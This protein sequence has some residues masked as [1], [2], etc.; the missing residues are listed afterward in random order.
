MK[1][2]AVAVILGMIWA[3]LAVEAEPFVYDFA[4]TGY[5]C[6]LDPAGT[7]H[8][9]SDV[10]FTGQV[11]VNVVA[12]LPTEPGSFVGTDAAYSPDAWVKSDFI[13]RWENNTY[14]PAPQ[15]F[16]TSGH[17]AFVLN[18]YAACNCDRI[19]N[20]EGYSGTDGITQAISSASLTRRTQNTTW[21]NDVS[22]NLAAGLAPVLSG[23]EAVHNL[24]QITFNEYSYDGVWHGF[25]GLIQLTSLTPRLFAT[26]GID[27]MPGSKP[28]TINLKSKGP[29][30]VAVLGSAA[31]DAT[32]VD[33]STVRFGPANALADH[34]GRVKISD[35][36]RDGLAD[37]VFEF[38]T[39]DTG[40]ECGSNIA[41][42]RGKTFI[43]G[44]FE[45][46]DSIQTVECEDKRGKK[47]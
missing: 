31:F 22:F 24:N 18:D 13:I 40:I 4:G 14:S 30:P 47:K 6:P 11:T 43:G 45:G 21:L 42:L 17:V 33:S 3:P 15:P 37:A 8:C 46:S 35:V 10:A 32:Q 19:D 27:I 39:E 20:T 9:V 2:R 36:N 29:I 16:M 7:P 23:G 34:G 26:V 41:S 12:P 25:L 1:T 28:K 38:R 44:T 5:F